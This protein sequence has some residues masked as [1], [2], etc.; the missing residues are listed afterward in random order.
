MGKNINEHKSI[1]E[2]IIISMLER[3]MV[4]NKMCAAMKHPN[5]SNTGHIYIEKNIRIR[6]M[7]N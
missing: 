5:I 2:N 7:Y 3:Q 1:G 6:T 4:Q